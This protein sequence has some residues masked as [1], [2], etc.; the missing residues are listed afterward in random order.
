M[1]AKVYNYSVAADTKNASCNAG[2]LKNE[3]N[4]SASITPACYQIDIFGDNIR[5]TMKDILSLEE[6]S[7]LTATVNAHEGVSGDVEPPIMD[8]GR[9]II[10]ADSRPVGFQTYYTMAGDDSTAGI[11]M[12]KCLAWDFSTDE[13]LVTG[14]HVP[15]GFK[16]KEILATFI[17]PI[18][19]KDRTIYFFDAMWGSFINIDIVI[20]PNTYYPNPAGSISASMLGLTDGKIYANTGSDW[21]VWASYLKR[22]RFYQSCPMG[23]ELNAEG[24]SVMPIPPGWGIRGRIYV[25]EADNVSKGYAELE[26]HRCH[27]VVL[28]GQTVQDIIDAH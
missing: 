5:I 25:P 10:R 9:P 8:D 15:P 18:H 26:I 4:N 28:P 7:V 12:G 2:T 11:G 17:C 24:S 6:E 14:D 20:P 23:D 22:H 19:T 1:S 13:D 3:I 27:S 21:V 16:C